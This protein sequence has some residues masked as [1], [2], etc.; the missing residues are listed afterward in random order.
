ME[1][2]VQPQE[3]SIMN[4]CEGGFVLIDTMWNPM[5]DTELAAALTAG[6]VAC[7]YGI[8]EAE[9]GATLLWTTGA[10]I[11]AARQPCMSG[12]ESAAQLT[13]RCR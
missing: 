5:P 13:S 2:S 12:D 8:Q 10:G 1:K 7:S 9:V 11:F 3:S 4:R 6:G